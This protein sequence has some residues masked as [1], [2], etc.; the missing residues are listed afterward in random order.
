MAKPPLPPPKKKN[1]PKWVQHQ[2]NMG[3]FQIKSRTTSIHKLKVVDPETMEKC[4]CLR[5]GEIFCGP[6]EPPPGDNLGLIFQ[7][8]PKRTNNFPSSPNFRN[9]LLLEMIFPS[10]Y[11]A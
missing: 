8:G 6:S 9:N 10:K 11:S 3:I 2:K 4:R 1:Q 7:I 5:L